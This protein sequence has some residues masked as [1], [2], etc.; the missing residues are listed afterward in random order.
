MDIKGSKVTKGPGQV[1][2]FISAVQKEKKIKTKEE[3]SKTK[4]E[5]R[6]TPLHRV[7]KGP[8]PSALSQRVIIKTQFHNQ[9]F[10]VSK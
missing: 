10:P 2:C 3:V 7:S 9:H 8:P 1:F 6:R 4:L 5:Q